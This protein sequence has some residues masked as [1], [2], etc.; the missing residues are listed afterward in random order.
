MTEPTRLARGVTAI[1]A[2]K[3]WFVVA[4]YA[5][6]F[7]LTRMLGP[8]DFGLYA[9]VTSVVSVFN[10]VVVAVTLQAVSRFTARDEGAAGSVLRSGRILL[11]VLG[12]AMFLL[13][14][15]AAPLAG[16]MLHDRELVAPLRVVALVGVL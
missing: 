2:A 5:V 15:I 13:L 9:V 6:Y 14:Q 8:R 12:L 7:A 11:A 3:I 1:T 10:N 4:G 16:L